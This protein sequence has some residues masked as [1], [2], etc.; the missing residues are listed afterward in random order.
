[1]AVMF[2]LAAVLF[3]GAA[4]TSAAESVESRKVSANVT[5]VNEAHSHH[6]NSSIAHA[7]AALNSSAAAA[8]HT[9]HVLP[10]AEGPG[11]VALRN[12]TFANT[13]EETDQDA[14]GPCAQACY[15]DMFEDWVD[16][17]RQMNLTATNS[18]AP[19]SMLRNP[20]ARDR[21]CTEVYLDTKL[22][23]QNCSHPTHQDAVK[24][25]FAPYRYLCEEH[26]E[27]FGNA[28]SCL[29]NAT[30]D[31]LDVLCRAESTRLENARDRFGTL[32]TFDSAARLR[33]TADVCSAL[34]AWAQCSQKQTGP[35]CGEKAAALERGVHLVSVDSVELMLWQAPGKAPLATPQSCTDGREWLRN[36]KLQATTPG[37]GAAALKQA[38]SSLLMALGV[39][40]TVLVLTR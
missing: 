32:T 11:T 25:S 36:A 26:V 9:L 31:A 2:L 38:A 22:C 16:V 24:R 7:T 3:I 15:E 14:L 5:V 4:L 27:E 1:M 29:A 40:T 19:N 13:T 6:S 33:A 23:L 34:L 17:T 12:A 18:L 39:Y 10:A 30:R 20:R 8:N 35:R 37:G 21:F 28:S